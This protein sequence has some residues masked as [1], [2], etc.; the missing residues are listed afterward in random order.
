MEDR[1]EFYRSEQYQSLVRGFDS[2]E[3]ATSAQEAQALRDNPR[4]TELG[5]FF[6][7]PHFGLRY[8]CQTCHD[9]S[10]IA[11]PVLWSDGWGMATRRCPDC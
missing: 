7:E 10:K 8:T 4:A 6:D 11:E 1:G 5:T 9:T 2:I 3:V